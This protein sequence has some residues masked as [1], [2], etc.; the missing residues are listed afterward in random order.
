MKI[1]SIFLLSFVI[2]LSSVSQN[3][4]MQSP[5]GRLRLKVEIDERISYSVYHEQTEVVAASPVSMT[6]NDGTVWGLHPVLKNKKTKS[7]NLTVASPFYKKRE[8]PDV[9]QELILNFKGDYCLIF[10]VYNQGVAYR[11]ASSGKDSVIVRHEEV[12]L[13]FS[14]DYQTVVP[15]VKKENPQTIEEQFFNSFQ[16]TYSHIKM[17]ELDQNRLMFLPLLIELNEGK[18]LCFTEADLESYPGL[19]L[20]K[21]NDNSLKGIFAHYPKAVKQGGHNML[22]ALVT[23]REEFI[24]KCPGT[25]SYPWRILSVSVNDWELLDNDLVY[26]LASPPRVEDISWIKPGKVAWDWWNNWN[27]YGVDFRAGINNETYKYY[28]DFASSQGIEYVILDEGWSVKRK[29]D[30]MQVIPEIDIHELVQY[31]KERNVG[32]ILWAGYWA[33]NNDMENVCKSY[34]DMGVKGFKVDFMDRDDQA[35]VDFYYR[36]AE[37]AARYKM[38]VD[39]HGAYKPT[40]LHRTFPN[41]L[42]FEGVFG[43]EQLKWS[44]PEV[45]MVTYDV[46]MPYIR[47]LAGPVDYTQGA[48]RNAIRKNYRPVYSE[49]MSQGTRC[50]QLAE[51]VIFDSPLNMLCDNPSN[52]L[53][54]PECTRFIAEIPTV[55]DE[56]RAI[57]GK[58]GEFTVMARQKGDVWYVGGLTNWDQRELVV[59]LSFLG[60]GNFQVEI[61]TD[62]VN[63][64]RVARDYKKEVFALPSGKKMTVR[65]MSGGGFAAKI[66]KK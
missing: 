3:L 55:W 2:T 61:F 11:F 46:T 15:Y 30:L 14:H 53:N 52:Y 57:Y 24:A 32:I 40:G 51:Y 41:V 60:E 45:D 64:D 56:T 65:M 62:G 22:Q 23:S 54:E 16:N 31:G 35:M 13:N 63:A 1:A 28:I 38:L 43:L 42:N 27:I 6:L 7:V 17:G 50:R 39:F 36:C 34:S 8:I 5:D 44:K 18:K 58:I 12:L 21:G 20:G 47:M 9:Y 48:M 66:M 29:A 49:P 37:T 4:T 25:R 10:R 26:L 33:M 59:D 19:Y